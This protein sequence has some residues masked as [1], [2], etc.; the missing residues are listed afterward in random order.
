[1]STQKKTAT[2]STNHAAL[3][4]TSRLSARRSAQGFV[5]FLR[6]QSVVGLAIGLILGTQAKDL[7]DQLMTSFINPITGLLLP[8][9]GTLQQKV[10]TLH[11]SGKAEKF[12]WG[13]FVSSTITFVIVAA[14][15]Y[16]IF[17]MLG[18]DKLDKQKAS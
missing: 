7:V 15:V 1:M 2:T 18:L 11:L 13:A 5:E 8:G 16:I 12:G 6:E 3:G 14:V 17:K 9:S 10:F 4:L